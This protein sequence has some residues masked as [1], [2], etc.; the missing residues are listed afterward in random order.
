ML[1]E[2]YKWPQRFRMSCQK[3]EFVWNGFVPLNWSSFSAV[4]NKLT[5]QI[6][7]KWNEMILCFISTLQYSFNFIS[8]S[9]F[10]QFLFHFS[11]CC[12]SV[13]SFRK[14]KIKINIHFSLSI[15]AI[16][17]NTNKRNPRIERW[18]ETAMPPFSL[19]VYG[20]SPWKTVHFICL[21]NEFQTFMSSI[22]SSSGAAQQQ[23]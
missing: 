12:Y 7:M 16:P 22:A 23:A 17:K 19:Y 3:L 13:L 11:G 21:G 6:E 14:M 9:H 4:L 2:C 18:I 5:R 20:L 15:N 1:T 10:S 8:I